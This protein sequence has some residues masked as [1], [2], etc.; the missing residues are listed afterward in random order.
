MTSTPLPT[1]LGQLIGLVQTGHSRN[2]RHHVDRR[3][4]ED[5]VVSLLMTMNERQ[6]RMSQQLLD[7]IAA[8]AANVQTLTDN[9]AL[10]DNAV[11]TGI[12]ALKDALAKAG[13]TDPDVAVAVSTIAN[14]SASIAA[15]ASTVNA[16][17]QAI[18]AAV[19]AP[20]VTEPP[21]NPSTGEGSQTPPASGAPDAPAA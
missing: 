13:N 3:T 18:A 21:A 2:D 6:K 4:F 7:A 20:P 1:L 10:H 14:L 15:S 11:Q 17:T 12:A 16:E 19:S 8:L 5:A 9:V